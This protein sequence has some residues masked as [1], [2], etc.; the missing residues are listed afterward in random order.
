[1]KAPHSRMLTV[2]QAADL[3]Q[4]SARTI[5]RW[6]TEGDL[7][8]HQLGRCRRIAQPDLE[9]FLRQRREV[10]SPVSY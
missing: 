8:S 6:M 5:R 3:L 1:M 2:N 9:A 7:A 10:S 4:V